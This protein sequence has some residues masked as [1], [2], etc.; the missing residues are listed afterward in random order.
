MPDLFTLPVCCVCERR[1][2]S[3]DLDDSGSPYDADDPLAGIPLGPLVQCPDCLRLVC[4][5]CVTWC[6]DGGGS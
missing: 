1:E 4:P 5:E 6:C 3:T 2:G